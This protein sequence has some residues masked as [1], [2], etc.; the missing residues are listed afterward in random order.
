MKRVIFVLV[1]V[2]VLGVLAP[3]AFRQH[4][5]LS[6]VPRVTQPT[7]PATAHPNDATSDLREVRE[8]PPVRYATPTSA[9]TVPAPA[10]ADSGFVPPPVTVIGFLL[11]S[12]LVFAWPRF[13]ES[14]VPQL[15]AFALD[16]SCCRLR[17]R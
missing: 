9:N 11:I 10:E 12:L 8:R 17:N 16:G 14:R 4:G 6:G 13:F 5:Q 7:A 1:G 15:G 2:L 3:E